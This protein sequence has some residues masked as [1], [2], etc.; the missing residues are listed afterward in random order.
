MK[1]LMISYRTQDARS[2]RIGVWSSPLFAA[3]LLLAFL[4]VLPLAS[5]AQGETQRDTLR[6]QLSQ[7]QAA[8]K[9]ANADLTALQNE[10]DQLAQAH[11]AAEARLAELEIE[12]DDVEND[13]AQ[14][15]RDLDS[16]RAQLEERLVSLYKD[17]S[18]AS[19]RYLEVLFAETDLVSVLER[20]DMLT[21]MA[22][23]DQELFNAVKSYLE[24]SRAGK[25][26]LEEKK[27][28]Q[29]D[30][31]KELVRLQEET[32]TKRGAL[33]VQYRNLKSQI[34]TLTEEIR[35][36]DA[37]AAAAAAAVAAAAAAAAGAGTTTAAPGST[38]TSPGSGTTATGVPSQ[39]TSAAGVQAQ[40]DFIYNTFLVP[41]RSVLTGQMVMDVWA[42][43]GI[44]PAASLAVLNAETGMG[45]LKYGGQ[46]VGAN[47]FGCIRYKDNPVWLRS[48]DPPITYGRIE[49]GGR[50]WFTFAT[51]AE[52]MEAWARC[53]GY[54]CGRDCYRPLMNAG[55][56]V[57][58]ADIYYGKGVAGE[59]KYIARLQW[60]YGMLMEA[61]HWMGYNW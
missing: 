16:A 47:N 7:K 36:A 48:A 33:T 10:L 32:S 56:W 24:T 2:W 19:S 39:P 23:Q 12:I 50:S 44:S 15:E 13:I 54:G 40:A 4:L 29:K 17:G 3:V 58:F 34:A 49:V 30:Q 11:D 26:L 8:L 6:Q 41:R 1:E 59:A 53:I 18:S 52:G 57:A 51:P 61:A 20:F 38:A 14:A 35:Q 37:R 27:A 55:N 22:K 45:S 43:Y 21:K 5:P 31:M 28:E 9:Q 60:A 25:A 46:L 42:K